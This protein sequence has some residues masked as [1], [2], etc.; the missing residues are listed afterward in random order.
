VRDVPASDR[1]GGAALV[2]ALQRNGVEVVFGIPGVHNFEIYRHLSGSSIAHV[3]VRHEQAAAYAADGFARASGKPGVCLTTSGPGITNACTGGATSYADSIPVLLCSPGPPLGAEGLDLGLLHEMKDQHAHLDSLVMA[4]VRPTNPEEIGE[5]VDEVFD[6]WGRARRRP[7]HIELPIDVIEGAWS[8]GSGAARGQHSAEAARLRSIFDAAAPLVDGSGPTEVLQRAAQLLSSSRRPLL[9]LGGGAR[10]SAD[11][12]HKLAEHL[13]ALV[14]TTV[15]GKGTLSEHHPLS[16]GASI[17][18]KRTR[19]LF[20]SADVLLVIGSE[21][22]DSDLWG[23]P[24]HTEASVIRIDVDPH[25]LRKNLDATLT[26]C[27]DAGIAVEALLAFLC[28]RNASSGPAG[29]TNPVSP[30]GSG[31]M[32]WA[33]TAVKVRAHLRDEALA[34]GEAY[35]VINREL[36]TALP[37]DTIV[38]GDSAQVSY[39]G[40]VHFWP[41]DRPGR[42]LY[43]AGYAT[44][45][46]GLPSAIGATH[47]CRRTPVVVLVGD[48]G[49]LFS[50]QEL[51]TAV[52]Q[53]LPLPVV[54]VDNHGYAEIR[55]GMEE[56]GIPPIAVDRPEVDF[57]ALSRAFGGRGHEA[58]SVD[59][60][61]SRV[62]EALSVE[63]PTVISID[64]SEGSPR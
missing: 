20:E 5:V 19:L 42:F 39:F 53:R 27:M 49:F 3:A 51:L 13:G 29:T 18:L 24:I 25:Q 34:D 58:K 9:V 6:G 45:G 59:E 56:R 26:L 28:E 10:G 41:M 12:V 43:P 38:A 50:V 54:I 4:S 8:S 32:T 60:L 57:V 36:S 48:G 46:Y 40:T 16:L 52:E 31:R 2:A 62:V 21:L 35:E 17:R 33:G 7:V 15:N 23:I 1:N 55:E 22:G 30:D 63:G 37:E 47:A 64:V 14:I 11:S 44:L 61:C